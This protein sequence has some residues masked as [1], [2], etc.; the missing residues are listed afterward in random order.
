M[1]QQNFMKK[2]IKSTTL[3]KEKI[4]TFINENL[5]LK[6][7]LDKIRDELKFKKKENEEYKGLFEQYKKIINENSVTK[8]ENKIED[9]NEN[10][11]LCSKVE[12][13]ESEKM[14]LNNDILELKS[15]IEGKKLEKEFFE[16]KSNELNILIEN[17]NKKLIRYE[18]KIDGQNRNLRLFINTIDILD[19]QIDRLYLRLKNSDNIILEKSKII[20]EL[21][22]KINLGNISINESKNKYKILENELQEKNTNYNQLLIESGNEINILMSKIQHDKYSYQQNNHLKEKKIKKRNFINNLIK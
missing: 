22:N 19:R 7:N 5:E 17:M 3:L 8:S 11:L 20:S 4:N 15:E 2:I 14:I 1:K 13:L 16:N 21:E 9:K 6:L 12:K 10:L 18:K